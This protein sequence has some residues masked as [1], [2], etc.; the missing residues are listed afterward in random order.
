MILCNA[1]AI[2]PGYIF[3][4]GYNSLLYRH[5]VHLL[6]GCIEACGWVMNL[7]WCRSLPDLKVLAETSITSILR[8]N[9]MTNMEKT[10]SSSGNG[11]ITTV[12]F[13]SHLHHLIVI[14]CVRCS[15]LIVFIV[16]GRRETKH[17]AASEYSWHKRMKSVHLPLTPSIIRKLLQLTLQA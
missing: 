1:I 15:C 4:G 7:S 17:F 11:H 13:F 12:S 6:I 9:F 16:F 10:M 2:Y 14:I 8:W 5:T 3:F